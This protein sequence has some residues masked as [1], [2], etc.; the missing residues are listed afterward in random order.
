MRQI[1]TFRLLILPVVMLM[2]TAVPAFCQGGPFGRYNWEP[3]GSIGIGISAPVNPLATRVNNA[4]FNIAGG[5]GVTQGYTGVMIDAF[6]TNFGVNDGALRREGARSGY[7]RFWAVTVDP[8]VHVNPQGPAD[9]YITAGAGLYGQRTEFRAPAS[10]SGP[11]AGYD[12]TRT[13]TIY[14]LG[15]NGGAGFALSPSPDSRLKFFI[16]AR[17]HQLLTLDHRVSFIPVTVGVRF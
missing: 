6:F 13:D 2:L 1:S 10:L 12:L 4:G 14:R 16:E 8:V 17:Y 7:Q 5:F 15:V 11:G 3:T 9:F